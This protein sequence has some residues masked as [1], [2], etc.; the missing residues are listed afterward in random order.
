MVKW[1]DSWLKKIDAQGIECGKWVEKNDEEYAKCNL[2]NCLLKYSSSGLQAITQ[3]AQNKA[4]H[5][6][7]SKAR[8]STT[9]PHFSA[10]ININDDNDDDK[11]PSNS[12]AVMSTPTDMVSAAECT[13]LFKVAEEDFSFRFVLQFCSGSIFLLNTRDLHYFLFINSAL[14]FGSLVIYFDFQ[15]FVYL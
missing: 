1:H 14:N 6:E 4:E 12:V 7:I 11:A 8:F 3:H 9:Q 10:V 2:C 15:F 13:W 5:K